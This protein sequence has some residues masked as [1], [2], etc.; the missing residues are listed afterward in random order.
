MNNRLRLSALRSICREFAF[1]RYNFPRAKDREAY[2]LKHALKELKR[3]NLDFCERKPRKP[4][5]PR[6][7]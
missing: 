7:Q 5:K 3:L 2:A 6:K 4:R 1:R